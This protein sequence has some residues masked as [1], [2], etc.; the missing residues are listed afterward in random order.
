MALSQ[1]FGVKRPANLFIRLHHQASLDVG[2][3][4]RG[5]VALAQEN[6]VLGVSLVTEQEHALSDLELEV[7]KTISSR[8]WTAASKLQE[9]HGVGSEVL[10]ELEAKGLLIS[11]RES[12][13][14]ADLREKCRRIED[15]PW[16]AYAALYHYLGKWRDV[17]IPARGAEAGTSTF[18]STDVPASILGE[19][20][21]RHSQ[22][23]R[24]PW[25]W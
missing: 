23:T 4:L 9:L 25:I 17:Q 6:T 19:V 21:D 16:N 18:E 3:L 14:F 22:H 20:V 1:D 24:R 2:R 15:A 10:D 11:D 5:D 7:L 13:R 12:S 8:Q